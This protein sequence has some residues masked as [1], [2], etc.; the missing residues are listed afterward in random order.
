MMSEVV[1]FKIEGSIDESMS[2]F[3]KYKTICGRRLADEIQRQQL[4][5]KMI[6][7]FNYFIVTK[8]FKYTQW[9]AKKKD[10]FDW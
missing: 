6:K 5:T 7:I 9:H 10:Q 3:W 4:K 8:N 2:G 1:I